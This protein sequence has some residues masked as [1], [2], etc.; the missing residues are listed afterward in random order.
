MQE[1]TFEQVDVVAGGTCGAAELAKDAY[2]S[3]GGAAGAIIVGASTAGVGAVVGGF[4]G[5][6][7]GALAWQASKDEVTA[8]L[9]E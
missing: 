4:I 6:L 5:A 8:A 1:L 3:A 9:C 7:I 2:V